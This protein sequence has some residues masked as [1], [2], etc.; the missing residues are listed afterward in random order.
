[1]WRKTRLDRNYIINALGG[2][3]W[4]MGKQKQNILSVSLRFTLQGGERYIPVNEAASIAIKEVVYDN[5]R[6][7]EPQLSPEFIGHFTV[8]YTINRNK[9]AHEI[10]M[11]MINV[12]GYKEFDGYFYNH[13]N[14]R[15]EMYMGS[16]VIPNISYKINF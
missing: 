2:K 8:G 10:S 13:K 3:E 12:T 1:M 5:S 4:N 9:L 6:A 11:K 14:D 15:P 7:F 16:V